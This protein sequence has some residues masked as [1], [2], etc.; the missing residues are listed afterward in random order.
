MEIAELREALAKQQTSL[1][2][3]CDDSPASLDL[4]CETEKDLDTEFPV[5]DTSDAFLPGQKMPV[6]SSPYPLAPLEQMETEEPQKENK[7][8]TPKL[9]LSPIPA[10]KRKNPLQLGWNTKPQQISFSALSN[11][12]Q[13][14]SPKK[15]LKTRTINDC[16]NGKPKKEA[17]KIKEKSKSP[18]AIIKL[19]D[20]DDD[21]DRVF[22]TPKRKPLELVLKQRKVLTTSP[23]SD[24]FD[25]FC[26]NCKRV[27]DSYYSDYCD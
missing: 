3:S 15:S 14:C 2:T 5:D 11:K 19:D 24:D 17:A 12:T 21:K 1:T 26:E 20:D 18:V 22:T 10:K 27:N 8:E 4:F 23:K 13:I 25:E 6:A 16:W 7:I 9:T